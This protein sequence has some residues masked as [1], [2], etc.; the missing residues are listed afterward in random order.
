M[1]TFNLGISPG[2]RLAR[3]WL[4]TMGEMCGAWNLHVRAAG[5]TV[6]VLL[7]CC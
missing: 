2:G 4:R 6:I 1:S 3:C 7:E 5:G